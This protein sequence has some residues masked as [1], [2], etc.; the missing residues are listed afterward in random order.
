MSAALLHFD[1]ALPLAT[2][3]AF[4]PQWSFSPKKCIFFWGGGEPVAY[5]GSQAKGRI[6]AADAGLHQSHSNVRP[7]LC[8]GLTLQLMAMLDS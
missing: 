6:R 7:E 4:L 5:G 8:T 2:A 3:L 1:L